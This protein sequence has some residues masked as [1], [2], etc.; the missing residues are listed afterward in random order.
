MRR[1][2]A[3]INITFDAIC[4]HTAMIADEELQENVNELFKTADIVVFN[5]YLQ[6]SN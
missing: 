1:L 3:S 6:K 2:V 5:I 4:D